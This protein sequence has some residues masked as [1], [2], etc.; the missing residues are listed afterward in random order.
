MQKIFILSEPS[1]AGLWF[2]F[3]FIYWMLIGA[4]VGWGVDILR[5]KAAGDE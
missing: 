1:S 5:S 3:H 2:L 4:L